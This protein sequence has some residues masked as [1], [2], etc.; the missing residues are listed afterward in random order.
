MK[1]QEGI[2]KHPAF[3]VSMHLSP[4]SP[5]PSGHSVLA[6]QLGHEYQQAIVLNQLESLIANNHEVA[7][8]L[9]GEVQLLLES[10]KT[11]GLLHRSNKPVVSLEAAIPTGKAKQRLALDDLVAP[12]QSIEASKEPKTTEPTARGANWLDQTDD[13][14]VLVYN[15][16]AELDACEIGQHVKQACKQPVAISQVQCVSPGQAIVHFKTWDDAQHCLASSGEPFSGD[17]GVWFLRAKIY[18]PTMTFNSYD[19]HKSYSGD[20]RYSTQ[21]TLTNEAAYG[22]DSWQTTSRP[23]LQLF[24]EALR[25]DVQLEKMLT[26]EDV[27][28]PNRDPMTLLQ[29]LLSEDNDEMAAK[30]LQTQLGCEDRESNDGI[31]ATVSENFSAT[32]HQKGRTQWRPKFR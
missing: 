17:Q 26:D 13:Y 10:Y 28:T 2:V 19:Q 8:H 5:D 4:I 27:L 1:F 29:T 21:A 16:P 22:Q 20:S 30:A 23:P 12:E 11:T 3:Q 32:A 25:P 15:L 14:Q 18:G 9:A 31:D 7:V 24:S 6:K